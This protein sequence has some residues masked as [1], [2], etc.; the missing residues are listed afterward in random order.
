MH[1]IFSTAPQPP[2]I[3]I[4]WQKRNLENNVFPTLN[5]EWSNCFVHGIAQ[6]FM[7]HFLK[8]CIKNKMKFLKLKVL[9]SL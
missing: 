6:F 4:A 9:P 8:R 2:S 7:L 5:F 1:N 3:I